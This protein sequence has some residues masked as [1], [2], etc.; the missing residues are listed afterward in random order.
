M[1]ELNGIILKGKF[2]EA[3][4]REKFS[5]IPNRPTCC[6]CA[7]SLNCTIEIDLVCRSLAN[8]M[9]SGPI[10]LRFDQDITYNLSKN[11]KS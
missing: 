2:Y 5:P 3:I 9:N 7:M 1:N 8:L 4:P 6:Q 10:I 11:Y